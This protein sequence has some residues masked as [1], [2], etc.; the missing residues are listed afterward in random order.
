MDKH[1]EQARQEFAAAF[2]AAP[3]A[4]AAAPGRV[5]VLGNHTDYNDGFILSAAIDRYIAVAGRAVPGDEARVFARSFNVRESF[6]IRDP[7][8]N[9]RNP[10]INYLAGVV[11]EASE[12]GCRVGGFEAAVYGSVPL[13]A[14]LSSSAALEVAAAMLLKQLFGL[15]L[16]PVALALMCQRAE[17]R[18]VGVQC[19]ILDPYS[20]AMGKRDHLI[21]LDCRALDSREHIPLGGDVELVL[22]NTRAAHDLSDGVYNRLRESCFRAAAHFARMIP[23]KT[24]THL[25]DVT[26]EELD[27]FGDGLDAV[28]LACARH[29]VGENDRVAR[30]AAALRAGDRNRMGACMFESH[31]SSRDDFRNSSEELDV[32]VECAAGLPGC[33]GARLS[34]GGFGG[35]TVNLVARDRAEAF[36]LALSE[37]YRERCGITPEMHRCRAVDGARAGRY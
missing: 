35:C 4:W 22:A 33:Y 26:P 8:L 20:S 12:A 29:V 27:R 21:F 32:M 9:A 3:S 10:W 1:L 7:R 31:R 17:N 30:G 23:G 6:N 34:G 14:G 5:E 37:K 15:A 36:A 11:K 16:P 2:S 28:D 13:G 24:I 19:G 18:F 25:R